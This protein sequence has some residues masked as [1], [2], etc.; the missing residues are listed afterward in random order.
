M[1]DECR[2][3]RRERARVAKPPWCF[4]GGGGNRFASGSS[5]DAFR[6]EEEEGSAC[7]LV[8]LAL[9][10]GTLLTWL[11]TGLG[12]GTKLAP[13]KKVGGEGEVAVV[14]MVEEGVGS[15]EAEVTGRR[16]GRSSS[17]SCE[18]VSTWEGLSLFPVALGCPRK[19]VQISYINLNL[20]Y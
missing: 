7:F 16:S 8:S 14:V 10:R 1:W 13:S 12:R 3:V 2:W 6:E 18:W 5:R 15:E 20:L 11:R 9:G 4:E 17:M 19:G